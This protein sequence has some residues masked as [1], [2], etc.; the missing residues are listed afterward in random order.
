MTTIPFALA[1]ANISGS[2]AFPLIVLD[3]EAA[4]S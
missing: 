2:P 1:Q 3:D 4:I